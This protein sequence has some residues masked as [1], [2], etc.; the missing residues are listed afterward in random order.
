MSAR[1]L[2]AQRSDSVHF[3]TDWCAGR[4]HGGQYGRCDAEEEQEELE[5]VEMEVEVVEEEAVVE[6]EEK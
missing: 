4:K 3:N 1:V 6:L 5:V 2:L